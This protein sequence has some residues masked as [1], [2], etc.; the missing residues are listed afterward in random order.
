MGNLSPW[1]VMVSRIVP[2]VEGLGERA[3]IRTLI[4]LI[5]AQDDTS[6]DV[7][8]PIQ[9][10]RGKIVKPAS[11]ARYVELAAKSA[12][13]DG[14][15]LVLFDAD[16]DCPVE[17][18]GQCDAALKSSGLPY[19]IAVANRTYESW[20]VA[21]VESLAGYRGLLDGLICPESPEQ[22]GN[23]KAWLEDRHR[24]NQGGMKRWRYRETIDQP[25]LT[26]RISVEQARR[27]RSFAHVENAIRRLAAA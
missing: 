9:L 20:F 11:L 23:P 1:G 3:S 16:D 17:L 5:V 4:N 2:I 8:S 14:G 10:D 18:V 26:S 7:N 21:S 24:D 19:E 12:G 13:A 25:G 15:I 22:V 27:S 6:V